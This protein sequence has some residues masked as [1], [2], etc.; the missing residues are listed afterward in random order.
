MSHFYQD[1]PQT[2]A[3]VNANY[4]PWTK[5]ETPED[6]EKQKEMDQKRDEKIQKKR[7]K[8]LG[9]KKNARFSVSE[10]SETS[11]N[12]KS[13]NPK[14]EKSEISVNVETSENPENRIFYR[15]G[16]PEYNRIREFQKLKFENPSLDF[17]KFLKN[18]SLAPKSK[19]RGN[20]K[21]NDLVEKVR[22]QRMENLRNAENAENPKIIIIRDNEDGE[23]PEVIQEDS[24]EKLTVPP[25]RP[26]TAK[27][28]LEKL[29][30]I[31]K[32]NE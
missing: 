16:T 10:D 28:Q 24:E 26:G 6:W 5:S 19:N 18:Q 13:E 27:K 15:V 22:K 7:S 2:A 30:G 29:A 8:S 25:R 14:P 3:E 17:S 1:R 20:F 32:F 31:L 9:I 21:L 4:H 12:L 23:A 11:E